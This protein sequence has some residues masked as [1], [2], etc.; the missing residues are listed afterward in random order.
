MTPPKA[1]KLASVSPPEPDA[2]DLPPEPPP[3]TGP[4]GRRLWAEVTERF[5]LNESELALL[6]EAARTLDVLEQLAAVVD[7]D[8]VMVTNARG[9]AQTHPAVV[10]GRQQRLALA[11]I[12]ATLRLPEDAEEA[13]GRPQR[14][15]AARGFYTG[16]GTT[17]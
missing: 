1:A 13:A 4:A 6:L 7:R 5:D 2:H 15:G 16:S 11:R 17:P 8:G 3:E 10:E 14:R 12:I 9:E